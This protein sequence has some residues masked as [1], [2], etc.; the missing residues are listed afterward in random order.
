MKRR[1]KEINEHQVFFE[2]P[3]TI[4]ESI[5]ELKAEWQL[6]YDLWSGLNEWLALKDAWVAI[7]FK[8]IGVEEIQKAVEKFDKLSNKC[9]LNLKENPV[10]QIFRD[11]V[12][13]IKSTMPVVT[14]LRDETLE[15]KHWLKIFEAIGRELDLEDDSFTLQSLIDLNVK[16][17]KDEIGEIVLQANKEHEHLQTFTKQQ[18]IWKRLAFDVLEHGGTYILSGTSVEEVNAQLEESMVTLSNTLGAKYVDFIEKEVRSFYKDLQVVETLIQEWT[19]CQRNWMYLYNIFQSSDIQKT[20]GKNVVALFNETDKAWREVM[21]GVHSNPNVLKQAVEKKER[22]KLALDTIK[23]CN[24]DLDQVQISLEELLQ[25]RRTDFPRFYFLSNDE[26]LQIMANASADPGCVQAHLRKIFDN[27]NRVVFDSTNDIERI[28]SG[29]M[30]EIQ[31]KKRVKTDKGVQEW[32]KTLEESMKDAVKKFIEKALKDHDETENL[33]RVEWVMGEHPAQAVCVV[34]SIVWCRTTEDWFEVE[35]DMQENLEIWL[36]DNVTNLKG[37]TQIVGKTDIDDRKRRAVVALITQDVHYRDIIEELIKDEVESK[38]D[39]KWQQQLRY[40][41][42]DTNVFVQQVNSQIQYCNEYMGCMSRLVI[43]PLTDRC[44]MT[45]TGAL[46]IKRG[47]APAGPAGTGKTESTKDL[48]KGLGTFCIVFNC[49]DQINYRMMEQLF[50]GLASTGSWACLD[51]FNRIDIEVLSVIAQQLLQVR[52]ALVQEKGQFML[53]SKFISQFRP[54][55]G[56]FITMNPGYKGRTELPDNLKVLFR[57]VS[58]MIPDYALI[59]EIMLFA[60]GFENAKPLSRKMTKLYKLASEQLSQQFHYDF[61]MRAV[62]SVLVMAGQ[63]K[64]ANPKLSEDIVLIR[65]MRDSNVPKF[66]KED[67]PLFNAIIKDLFP[68]VETPVQEYGALIEAIREVMGHKQMEPEEVQIGKII[69][70]YETMNVRFGMMVIGQT[71]TGKSAS[72]Q[73]LKNAQNLLTKNPDQAKLFKG[74]ESQVLNPKSITMDELYGKFD[75]LTQEWKDG[76]ASKIIREF[77]QREHE[78]MKWVI[79]DGPVDALWIENMNTVLDDTMTLCLSCGERLR[80]RPEMR[81]VFEVDDLS[82]ASPATVSRCGMVYASA[83]TLTWRPLMKRWLLQNSELLTEQ[84]S[85][86]LE[87]LFETHVDN[88]IA[89][90]REKGFKEPIPTVDNCFIVSMCKMLGAVLKHAVNLYAY[91]GDRLKKALSKVFVFCLAW[92]FGGSIEETHHS[93]F[94]IYLST[95]FNQPDL[96][97]GSI[98][99][100]KLV[101]GEVLDYQPWTATM[102]GF[103]YDKSKSFFELVVPTKDTTR[104]SWLLKQQILEENPIFFTGVTGV[105]KSII[106]QS[107]L[108]QL[109][110]ENN[111]EAVFLSF[112]SQTQS[113]ETQN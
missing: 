4:F 2:L 15:E 73:A 9:A 10:T 32:L 77:V 40:Y 42:N 11:K 13:E 12:E 93:S 91:E 97:R 61:G 18:E 17:Q 29:E 57:P 71:M 35:G 69:Q 101:M 41:K 46:H 25:T 100:S 96:P 59:A 62:K 67:L 7:K 99:D 3:E 72:I 64:R 78:D 106:V 22:R 50:A 76:L 48:A 37:L 34:G 5:D 83:N 23:K 33:N 95:V 39:F 63:I 70:I 107:T 53:G 21:K 102:P 105:G 75:V 26:L 66:L 20:I 84:V 6:K 104:F 68:G 74:V 87:G 45:I 58:M 112:S 85:D 36:Q 28:Q 14:F 90:I 19:Y 30:E 111:Y 56:V 94:D 98:F 65:A 108:E 54:T 43:T 88:L 8:E 27:I 1:G 109:K 79:F 80:L 44:W 55:M 51:E 89:H 24:A 31:F 49:S 81:M 47:A 82:Q 16:D 113:K 103:V 60:E 38:H 92:S 110:K 86:M 52:N